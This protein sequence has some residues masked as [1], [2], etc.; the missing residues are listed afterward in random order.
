MSLQSDFELCLEYAEMFEAKRDQLVQAQNNIILMQNE[1]ERLK[2]KLRVCTTL[3]ILS[4]IAMS[5]FALMILSEPTINFTELIP[6]V[7]VFMVVFIIVLFNRIKMKKESNDFESKKPSLI[8]QYTANAE[9]CER[10]IAKL[11]REI[12]DEDLF[13]IVPADYFSTVA[14]E[15]CLTRIRTKMATTAT[16][17]LRQ[18]EAEI[19]RLEHME[20]LEQM[21]NAR[22][23]KLEDV[24]RAVEINTLVTLALEEE[25]KRR[26][27]S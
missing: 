9:K 1:G 27:N 12:Y 8:Q 26:R 2:N 10:E 24:K 21:N 22:M 20:H 23:E 4:F 16:E 17:A 14:I 7:V 15:F 5:F 11:I 25:E 6:F 18:L 3:A 19:K 13:D